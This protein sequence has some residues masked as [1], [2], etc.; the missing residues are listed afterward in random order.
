MKS[1]FAAILVVA[2]VVAGSG[3]VPQGTICTAVCRP[4]KPV[5][6]AGQDA[7]GSEGCWGCCQPLSLSESTP[8]VPQGTICTAVCRPVKPVCPAGQGATGSEGCWGCCQ[9]GI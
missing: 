6:P 4:V 2:T 7:S 5:C 8:S 9:P 1:F 3:A